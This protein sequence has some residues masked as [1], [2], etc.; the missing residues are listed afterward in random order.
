MRWRRWGLGE[1]GGDEVEGWDEL[2]EG[3]DGVKGVE[4]R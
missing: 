2:K 4:M 1:G 3:G